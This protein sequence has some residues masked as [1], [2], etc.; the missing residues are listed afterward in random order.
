[1]DAPSTRP[2]SGRPPRELEHEPVAVERGELH[3]DAALAGERLDRLEEIP[4]SGRDVEKREPGPG[5]ADEGL[6]REERGLHPAESPVDAGE[7]AER[8]RDGLH[9]RLGIHALR[10]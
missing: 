1:M 9:P 7:V 10:V 3:G 4:P 8:P 5:A 6:E 2:D